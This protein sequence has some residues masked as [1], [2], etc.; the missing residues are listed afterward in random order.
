[1]QQLKPTTLTVVLDMIDGA[2]QSAGRQSVPV[3]NL[4]L[5][6]GIASV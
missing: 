4:L 2:V 1:M 6:C 3:L 5:V